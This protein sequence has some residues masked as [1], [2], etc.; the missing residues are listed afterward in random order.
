MNVPQPMK[1][2]LARL[3][4]CSWSL[5]PAAPADLVSQLHGL[6]L[7]RVQLD[8]DPLRENAA[9][10]STLPAAR[11]WLATATCI[12]GVC[13]RNADAVNTN[14]KSPQTTIIQCPKD[15]R[16]RNW[17]R[18][19]LG[20][21]EPARPWEGAGRGLITVFV[22]AIRIGPPSPGRTPGPR[23]LPIETTHISPVKRILALLAVCGAG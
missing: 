23:E 1:S 13:W 2:I 12:V 22:A 9:V 8:L 20:R 4:V 15:R 6:G 18:R 10:W 7:R 14:A 5:Q 16:P 17:R 19:F 3:A 21:V 11:S